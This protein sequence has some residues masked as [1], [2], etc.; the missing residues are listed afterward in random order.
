MKVKELIPGMLLSPAGDN[1]IFCVFSTQFTGNMPYMSVRAKSTRLNHR[2][3]SI[4]RQKGF[5]LAVYLG[6]RKDVNVTKEE[7][8]WADRYV[9][10]DNIV[11][12]VDPSAWR[13]I[14]PAYDPD[15]KET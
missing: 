3:V 15:C 12:A 8:G 5:K 2:R 1:E 13:R 9:M 4:S 6:R 11:A 14:K 10:I 7:L